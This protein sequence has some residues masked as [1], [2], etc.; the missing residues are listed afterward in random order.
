M[1]GVAISEPQRATT[2][3]WAWACPACRGTLDSARLHCSACER[4]F[5]EQDGVYRFLLPERA[6][7]F[8]TFVRDYR[9]VRRAE[10]WGADDAAYYRAL[11]W[12]DRSGR[13][14]GVWRIR[15]RSF[16]VL[17]GMLAAERPL[18]VLDL[19]AGPCWLSYQLAR[20]GHHVAAVDVQTDPRDG[21][22]AW[23][24]YD[25]PFTPVQAEFDRLPFADEQADAVIFN[26]ALHYAVDYV[27]T[28][29]ESLRVLHRT[30]RVLVLDSP[31]YDHPA[32]GLAMLRERTEQFRQ[33][34]GIQ[35]VDDPRR[36]LSQPDAPGGARTGA[37]PDLAH[38][39]AARESSRTVQPLAGASARAASGGALSS[40]GGD[41][42]VSP[43][44]AAE[45]LRRQA[46]RTHPPSL[47]LPIVVLMA[48]SRCNSRCVMCDIWQANALRRRAHAPGP[49]PHLDAFRRLH[50][51]RF[52][53]S[54]GEALMHSNLWL[55]CD[56]LKN[57]IGS[58]ITLLSTGLLLGPHADN[59][60]R[61]C[62]EV[63][64]SLDG[65]AAVHDAIRRIPRAF[66]RLEQ[67]IAALR[68]RAPGYPVSARC[69]L[70]R[71]NF[72]DLPNIISAA[73]S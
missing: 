16:S 69:V 18:R 47:S 1:H 46:T 40:P 71:T 8:A 42:R 67:G 29:R 41:T 17:G 22:G 23:T 38:S 30:G 6:A 48:H 45:V 4:T 37:R 5:T 15:A 13:F 2:T 60:V 56:L 20:R 59:V 24:A 52:V 31:Y 12:H 57:E 36:G 7:H 25:A 54:G 14:P 35:S 11:P 66:E 32:D 28:L 3:R 19:G 21:L 49:A 55:L 27:V 9:T 70:Q 53:L 64:V 62:D 44:S 61:W 10:G 63:I 58:R 68:E 72:R 33:A 34:Y 51:Q 73:H 65:S 26:G 50:V 39:L 43:V